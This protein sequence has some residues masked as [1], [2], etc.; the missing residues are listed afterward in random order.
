[1]GRS[2]W[3][4]FS[5]R[6]DRGS[7]QGGGMMHYRVAASPWRR[8]AFAVAGLLAWALILALIFSDP[9]GTR[10]RNLALMAVL[11]AWVT[12]FAVRGWRGAAL[13]ATGSGVR[14]RGLVWTRSWRWQLIGGFAAETRPVRWTWLPIRV[15]RRIMGI[16]LRGGPTLWLHELSCRPH[17]DG[18]TRVDAAVVRL[19]ELAHLH[20]PG[21]GQGAAL[22]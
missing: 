20:G 12:V 17:R 21:P 15:H 14:F 22:P 4:T 5:L 11:L 18:P 7:R 6:H 10:P 3:L 2:A 1:M 9:N 13:T 19:N 8:A 16:H